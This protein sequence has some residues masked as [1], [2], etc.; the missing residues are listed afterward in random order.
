[1][2]RP[3]HLPEE[4]LIAGDASV[5]ILMDRVEAIDREVGVP[6]GWLFLMTHGNR[7]EPEVGQAIAKGLRDQRVVLPDRDARVLQRWAERPYGF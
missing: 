2:P 4:R 6:F 3:L 7:V 1:M 5:H